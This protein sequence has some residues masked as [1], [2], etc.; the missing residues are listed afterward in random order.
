AAGRA[1]L[2]GG[3]GSSRLTRGRN[4]QTLQWTGP[5]SSVL[6]KR[7]LVGAVPAIERWS[8]RRYEGLDDEPKSTV[9]RGHHALGGRP[10]GR[11]LRDLS[12]GP[13]TRASTRRRGCPSR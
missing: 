2:R 1:L 10:R 13:A 3:R 9:G 12:A 11:E 5:A 6:V 8:V 7:G 4:N